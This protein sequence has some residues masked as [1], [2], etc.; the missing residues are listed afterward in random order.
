MKRLIEK[1]LMFGNMIRVDSPAWVARYNRALKLVTGRETAL[2]EFHIDLAGFSPEVGDEIGDLDY[3]NPEGAHRQ[4]ILLTTEQKT[5]PLLNADLSVLRELLKQFIHDNESQLFSLT[6]RDAVVGEM[7]DMVWQVKTPAD[8]LQI[9]RIRIS[10]D[11]TGNHVANADKLT[12]LIQRF[13]AEPTGWYDDVLIAQMIAQAK[14]TGDVIRNPVHLEVG[15]YDVPD[16]WTSLFGGVYVFRSPREKAMIFT[17]ASIF[18]D[19]AHDTNLPGVKMMALQDTNGIAMWLARNAL[20]E[21][22]ITAKGADGAAI[23]RQKIDFV[24]ID[25]ATKLGIDTGDGTR[26]ALR[27]AAARMGAGLPAEIRGL[28]ALLRYAEEGGAWP[29]ID[30]ADPAYFYAIRASAG[31]ARD[32]VNQLLTELAPHDVRALF[33]MHKPLFYKRYQTWEEAKKEYVANQLARE[34]QIDKQGTREALFGP[35][36]GMEEPAAPT[37][38]TSGPWGPVQSASGTKLTEAVT[39][40]RS[41]AGGLRDRADPVV[42]SKPALRGPWGK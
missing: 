36:P 41:G 28:S 37:A 29:V 2:T 40:W 21:P 31:P 30:S 18:T 9:N 25:A 8:L 24:L 32:L 6:A 4:F 12:A 26:S 10:A 35:E 3:L 15:E 16:F 7:D 14:E 17:D 13:R 11:T 1:G 38:A 23:L 42:P 22:I 5:A 27:R 39:G 34:Y 33:I 20:A 19:P